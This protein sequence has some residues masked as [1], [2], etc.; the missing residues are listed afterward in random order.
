MWTTTTF[1][2][3]LLL[4]G[5]LIA[6]G[7]WV[8]GA[9]AGAR[10][11][12]A[13]AERLAAARGRCLSL[14]AQE[15]RGPGLALM[16]AADHSDLVRPSQD[17]PIEAVAQQLLRLAD[18]L[19]DFAT[20]PAPRTLHE[21]P[22]LLGPVVD[23]AIANVAAQL[24]PGQRHW[25]ITPE[26][27]SLRVQADRRALEGALSA[28]LRRAAR[29]S[30]DGDVVALR[31][32]LGAETVAIIVEDEGDGLPAQDLVTETASGLQHGMVGTAN[33]TRGLD[34]GLTLARSLAVAH[35]GDIRLESAPGIG[36]RAW[37]TLPSTRVLGPA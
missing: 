6:L 26:L 25:K 4:S 33:G 24:R 31:H 17:N 32:V 30:R 37:L 18:D 20:E 35:G 15:L 7:L 16:A 2:A 11:R 22:A 19:A 12:V 29:H 13:S 23:A 1:A 36:A 34:L 28:L 14:A 3:A 9:L 21:A 5:P 27:R 8:H 10:Q